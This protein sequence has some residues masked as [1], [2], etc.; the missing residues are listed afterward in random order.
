M[1]KSKAKVLEECT[2]LFDIEVP[3]EAIDKAFGEVYD[4]ITKVANIPG[5]RVGKAP[6][7]MVKKHYAG[8]AREEVLKRLIPDAITGVLKEHKIDPIGM[9]EVTELV[10]E[11]GKPMTFKAKVE[12]RPAFKLKNYKGIKLDKKKAVVNDDDVNKA[13]ENLR[14]LN[15]KY[16]S[17]EDRSVQMGDY[18]VSDLECFV[19]GK[20]A[21]KKR[22][23]LWLFIDK[24]SLIPTLHEKMVGMK[25]GEERD[26]EVT[27]PEKYPDKSIAGKQAKYH[28]LAKEIKTRILPPV[29]DEL[30]KDLGKDNLENLKKEIRDEL[31]SRM[32]MGIEIDTENQLLKKLTDDNVFTVPPSLV[33]TQLKYMVENAKDKLAEKG[34]DRKELDQ[35]DNDLSEKFKDDAVRQVR[36]LFILDEI[37]TAEKID[38]SQADVDDAYKAIA[39]QT[40]KSETEIKE[41]Y[42]KQDLVDR[43]SDKL[44]EGKAVKFLLDNAQITEK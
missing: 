21:H 38:V 13:V 10:F 1:A 9:P 43:L 37:A 27:L 42:E 19:D 16:Q 14:Q 15:A 6:L 5:F 29:D 33:K 12:T 40:G 11:E 28:I 7:D 23:N 36:L 8:N 25:K 34:F 44:R 39:T 35:K 41:Y 2:T 20:P 26:I 31:S 18:V 3:R 4:E 24:E 32:K 30:A 17:V 22:E